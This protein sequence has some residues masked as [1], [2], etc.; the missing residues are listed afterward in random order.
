MNH[1]GYLLFYIVVINSIGYMMMFMDKQRAIEGRYRIP[2]RHLW[3]VS[4]MGGAIGTTLGMRR[5][6]HKT[7]HKIFRFGFPLIVMLQLTSVIWFGFFELP[8]L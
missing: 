4:L 8:T 3:L 7:K 5:F 1:I 6:R 2:E